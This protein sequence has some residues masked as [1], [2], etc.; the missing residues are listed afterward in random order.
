[1]PVEIV[2]DP[3]APLEPFD[4]AL[5]VVDSVDPP[6]RQ[7][8]AR[9]L[10]EGL[11]YV[12]LVHRDVWGA[13]DEDAQ[14]LLDDVQHDPR[15]KLIRFWR[16]HDD[17]ERTIRDEVFVLDDAAYLGQSLRDGSFVK[18]GTR[19]E[20]TWQLENSGFRRW[21]GRALREL[22]SERLEPEEA[23][24]SIPALGPGERTGVSVT[25][26]APA[27]PATCGSVWQI[28]DADGRVAFPWLPGLRCRIRAVL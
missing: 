7:A 18:V 1:V 13:A 10:A 21:H 23:M 9:V 6:M 2:S 4:L 11:P 25:F 28:V 12:V 19:F 16:G 22:A 8:V 20:Q 5:L 27:E 14:A 3:S 24:V 26:T 15:R 17:L